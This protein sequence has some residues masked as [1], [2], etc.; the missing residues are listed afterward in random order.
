MIAGSVGARAAQVDLARSPGLAGH[1]G[2]GAA[3][4]HAA[5]ESLESRNF[6]VF[7]VFGPKAQNAHWAEAFAEEQLEQ[8]KDEVWYVALCLCGSTN[9]K[10]HVDLGSRFA[11]GAAL[12]LFKVA[13][14]TVKTPKVVV[15]AP[16]PG[17]AE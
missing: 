1:P 13:L 10:T 3:A 4:V 6:R 12:Y 9:L 14:V 8:V 16:P 11:E 15:D 7:R 5:T 17:V 2:W